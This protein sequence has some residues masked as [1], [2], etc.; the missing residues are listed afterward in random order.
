[1][2]W[3]KHLSHMLPQTIQETYKYVDSV[4]NLS[5]FNFN[6]ATNYSN[7][8]KSN[9]KNNSPRKWSLSEMVTC[10]YQGLFIDFGFS[11]RISN[12]EEGKI[13]PYSY[14]D[15]KWINAETS[16]ILISYHGDTQLSKDFY[17]ISGIFL[18]G[19]LSQCVQQVCGSWSRGQI[20][21]QFRCIELFFWFYKYKVYPIGADALHQ[22]S[23]VEHGHQT[24]ATSIYVLLFGSGL[25]VKF[26][27][28]VFFHVIC[29]KNSLQH[30]S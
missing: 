27:L 14:K 11:G 19:I 5:I 12:N 7:C 13:I 16:W 2:I 30:R 28:Y 4:P 20:L 15:N 9:T 23:P 6:D 24:I 29:I 21:L 22:N 10:T 17:Q 25:P 26:W 3:H 8:I 1:M 18:A